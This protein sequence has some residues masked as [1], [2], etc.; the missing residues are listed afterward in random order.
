M[1]EFPLQLGNTRMEFPRLIYSILDAARYA[2][3]PW[4]GEVYATEVFVSFVF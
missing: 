4:P 3:I 1:S 2:C